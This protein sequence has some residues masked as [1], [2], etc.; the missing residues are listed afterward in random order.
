LGTQRLNEVLQQAQ[1]PSP[2]GQA[3]FRRGDKVMQLKNDYEREVFNGDLGEVLEVGREGVRVDMG[4]RQVNY[5]G[6]ALEALAL[7]YA[8]TI[9]KVQ[10]S[11]FPAVVVVLHGSHHLLL[12]RAL[13]Y[14]A[15]TRAKRLAVMLGAPKAIARAVHN[16]QLQATNS[17]LATRLR[18]LRA[19]Q[20]QPSAAITPS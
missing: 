20:R 9:H 15:I 7:A 13:L 17:K 14:T 11:E 19:R 8:S 3:G 18:D 16:T 1:N 12:S 6:R 5:D 10:G 2:P 4:G